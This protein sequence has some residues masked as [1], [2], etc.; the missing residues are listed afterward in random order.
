MVTTIFNEDKGKCTVINYYNPCKTLT[1]DL[2]RS[3]NK[4]SHRE[5]W[6]GDLMLIIVYGEVD[7]HI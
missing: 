3:I 4:R 1:N 7:I 6:C 2:M 5:I